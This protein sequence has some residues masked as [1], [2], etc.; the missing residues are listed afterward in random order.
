MKKIIGHR[1]VI[2]ALRS[3]S[4]LE[5][6][7]ILD[8]LRGPIEKEVRHLC[9]EK[10]VVL[11]RI[12]Q[13]KLDREVRGNHQGVFAL[14]SLVDY[15]LLEDLIPYLF[16]KGKNPLLLILDSIKDV[17]NIGAIA[18][19][20]EVFGVDGLILPAKKGGQIN[21]VT[22]KASAGALT[23]I[24]VCRVPTTNMAVEY[25]KQSGFQVVGAM[26]GAPLRVAE[27][28]IDQPTVI[29][30]GSEGT[31]IDRNLIPVLDLI[32]SIP[33]IGQLDSLNVSVAAGIIL[34]ELSKQRQEKKS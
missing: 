6:V 32:F 25:L 18:R 34:Y 3:N 21:E 23:K 8:T 10:K 1:P 24:P 13:A 15:L 7:Y 28:E 27:L 12:P 19:S 29:I 5:R 30:L 9:K 31:G 22:I 17:R 2:E 11:S 16:D 26:M 14:A 4:K 33:Q 20:A